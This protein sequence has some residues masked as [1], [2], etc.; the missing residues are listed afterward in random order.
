M[1]LTPEMF[2]GLETDIKDIGESGNLDKIIY[3]RYGAPYK[4]LPMVSRL[5]Q[6][7]IAT[8]YLV[9]DDLQ[10][11]INI[12]LEAGAGA[13]GWTADLVTYNNQTQAQFN[14]KYSK[15]KQTE[16]GAIERDLS[17][18]A[19]DIQYA[20]DYATLQQA[21]DAKRSS[22]I[23]LELGIKQYTLTSTLNISQ[24]AYIQGKGFYSRIKCS[25]INYT[26]F[27]HPLVL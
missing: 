15:F 20:D 18:R 8:G 2:R 10:D 25:R 21:V 1:A 23:A 11:A 26:R 17:V 7:M 6:E 4:S 14:D 27:R 19:R 13:A 9:I 16:T 12:A 3:P 22:T 24:Y 5:F